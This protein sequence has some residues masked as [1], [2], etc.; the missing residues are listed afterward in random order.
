MPKPILYKSSIIQDIGKYQTVALSIKREIEPLQRISFYSG[1]HKEAD[2]YKECI[3][4]LNFV[5]AHIAKNR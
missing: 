2:L 5:Y 3:K 4:R 1:K